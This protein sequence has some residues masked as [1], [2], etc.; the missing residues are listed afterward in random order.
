MN[1]DFVVTWVDDSDPEWR[2][3]RA[4]YDKCMNETSDNREERYRDYGIFKYW[5]RAVETY[6]PWVNNIFLVTWGHIPEWLDVSNPKIQIVKHEEFIPDKYL[7]TFNSNVIEWNIHRIKG[8]SEH[9]VYF[10]DDV[11]LTAPVEKEFFYRNGKPC[12]QLEAKILYNYNVGEIFPYT[13]FNNMGV[14]NRNFQQED[15]LRNKDK[16]ISGLYT[17]ENN[18]WN[19]YE[20][21][22]PYYLG[23]KDYHTAV[24]YLKSYFEKV[25]D[26]E[27]ELLDKVCRNRFRDVSDISIWIVRY[28]QL[29]EGSFEIE[30]RSQTTRYFTLARLNSKLYAAIENKTYKIICINDKPDIEKRFNFEE[31]K[32]ELLQVFQQIFPASSQ[33]EKG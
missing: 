23:F 32:K 33:F 22:C 29:I 28:W 17:E 2:K 8:L 6:A 7:P 16:W 11:F 31:K 27:E 14:I 24:S 21:M 15:K 9:F 18:K 12:D 3:E 10:N 19:Q 5:F 26:K 4:R 1:I 30:D 20:M 25:W 13:E